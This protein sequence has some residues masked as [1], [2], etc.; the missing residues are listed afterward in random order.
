MA[1]MG[2]RAGISGRRSMVAVLTLAFAFSTVILLI[3]ELDRPQQGLVRVSQQAMLDLQG[4][5]AAPSAAN[6]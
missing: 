6:P 3:T 4:K 2:Y 1:M 5:L